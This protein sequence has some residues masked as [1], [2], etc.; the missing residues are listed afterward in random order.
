MNKKV[1]MPC[2]LMAWVLVGMTPLVSLAADHRHAAVI[3]QKTA[4]TPQRDETR[5]KAARSQTPAKAP[6][7]PSNDDKT[8]G[9]AKVESPKPFE[10]SEK[11]K[12]DQALDFPADI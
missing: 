1:V 9:G 8:A 2:L 11:V 6:I 3:A 12:A 10:P 7:A 5:G 4:P